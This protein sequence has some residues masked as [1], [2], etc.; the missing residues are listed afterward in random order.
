MEQKQTVKIAGVQ[1]E[2]KILQKERNLAR[3]LE[4]IQLTAKEGARL[5]IFPECAL[6]GYIF[7][8]LEEAMPVAEP[9][10]GPSI[11]QIHALCKELQVYVV[12]G[13]LERD[14]DKCYNT[15][16]LLG[17]EGVV[18]KHRKVHLPCVG[19]DRFVEHGDIPFAVYD[20]MAGR[21]GM[22]I[23]YDGIFPE[24]ARVLAL[25]GAD[26][27]VL[28]TN[29]PKGTQGT[30]KYVV[31]TRAIENHIFYA[32]VNRVGEERGITFFGRSRIAYWFGILADG[33]PNEEDILYAE[34]EPAT[35]REKRLIAAPG[36]MEIDVIHDRRP[37]FYGPI[38]HTVREEKQ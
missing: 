14:E 11:D 21:I 36:E 34:I 19:I 27:V 13:L 24:H 29:W 30:P 4:F 10:P 37:D 23:C 35:A 38:C 17:P 32:A 26:L 28:P 5:I 15:A 33:K 16:A 31:P 6:S 7:S 20:T 12:M 9:I 2:P 1:M 22:G 3:C 25:Q 8:S 18:G